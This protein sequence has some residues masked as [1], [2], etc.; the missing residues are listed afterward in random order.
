MRHRAIAAALIEKR[1]GATISG[2]PFSIISLN[3]DSLIEDSI[4]WVLKQVGAAREG[5]GLAARNG[6]GL[7]C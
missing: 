5:K 7:F 1:I 3:W 6:L 2:D 4:F